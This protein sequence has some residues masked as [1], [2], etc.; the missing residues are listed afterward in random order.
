MPWIGDT[1]YSNG[2][3]KPCFL[4]IERLSYIAEK[5]VRYTPIQIPTSSQ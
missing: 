3:F 5:N 4:D 1:S 2:G